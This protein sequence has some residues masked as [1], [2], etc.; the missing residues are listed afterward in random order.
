MDT[1]KNTRKVLLSGNEALAQGAYEAGLMHA[2]AYPGTPSTEIMEYLSQFQEIDCQWSVNEKVAYEVAFGASTGGVRSL[3]SAKHVG[4]NVAMDPL[5]TSAYIGVN[6]GF[7]IISA[8]DPGMHSSQNEQDNRLFARAAKIPMLEPSTPAEAKKAVKTAFDISEMF[9]IP[10][11]IRMTTRLSHTKEDV[12]IC[13]RVEVAPKKFEINA[14]KCVM[15]PKN[16]YFRHIDLEERLLKLQEYAESSDL[17]TM[18]INDTKIGFISSGVPYLYVKDM[19]PDASFLKLGMPYPFP[20]KLIKEFASKVDRVVVIEELEPFLEEHLKVLGLDIDAKHP[21]F[22]IGELRPELIPAVVEGKEK[23]LARAGARKPVMCPGCSH[24]PVFW[25]LKQ[26]KAIVAGDIGCYTLASL[27][28]MSALHT[29]VC[30]GGGITVAEGL[31]RALDEKIVGVVGDSTFVHSGITGLVNAAY[32]QRKGVLFVLD[33]TTTA[34][35]GGQPNPATGITIRGEKTKKLDI[36]KMCLACGADNADVVD[37]FDTQALNA[38]IK[39]RMDED[40]LSVIIAKS[41]CRFIDKSK[42][43][44]PKYNKENCK[45]CGLCLKI[46]C[47]AVVQTEDG[48]VEIDEALCVGC[49]LCVDVCPFN[50][51]VRNEG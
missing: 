11:M 16:A 40:A 51:L 46:D 31:S 41:P 45:K 47:P 9:D 43:P 36:Q 23:D 21:S 32:N 7:V 22:R 44:L 29:C 48:F 2:A 24:R 42:K 34:M 50:A 26:T 10:V 14:Q 1:T 20:D 12:E 38:L 6:G 19:Y 39:K 37:P 5:M 8:D 3:F 17:N 49:N 33:N 25:A 35:T 28:P 15:V 18:H 13:P 30:M 27:P 4:V